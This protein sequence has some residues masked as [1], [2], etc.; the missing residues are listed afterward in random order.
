MDQIL[1]CK[2]PQRGK[3]STTAAHFFDTS[4]RNFSFDIVN[5]MKNRYSS[6]AFKKST[7][8]EYDDGYIDNV[9]D[10]TSRDKRQVREVA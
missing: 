8:N 6:K 10:L 3:Q 5:E 1:H 2:M 7:D 4:V 9:D